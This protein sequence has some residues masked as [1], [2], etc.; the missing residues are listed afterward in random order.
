MGELRERLQGEALM[1]W[2]R[3]DDNMLSH[4]KFEGI[5]DRLLGFWL[6]GLLYAARNL[7]DGAIPRRFAHSKTEQGLADALVSRQLWERT[8]A[9]WTIHHFLDLNPSKEQTERQRRLH[10]E[11]QA[12]Y[13]DREASSV[14]RHE[15][16]SDATPSR[17]VPS[18]PDHT[19]PLER[20][21][22]FPKT[23]DGG[24]RR[25]PQPPNN[26]PYPVPNAEATRRMLEERRHG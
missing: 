11:R 8:D 25:R 18:L 12:R 9:G 26:E 17:P 24:L 22:I 6:R 14:T 10:R 21:G 15:S 23:T 20:H 19:R 7:S 13:R 16:V 2:A 5:S 1:P 3:I 4:H